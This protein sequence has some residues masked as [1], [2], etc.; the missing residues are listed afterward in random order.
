MCSGRANSRTEAKVEIVYMNELDVGCCHVAKGL[1]LRY[2]QKTRRLGFFFK[3]APLFCLFKCF[4][5]HSQVARFTKLLVLFPMTCW[6]LN[7]CG[8]HNQ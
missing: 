2:A 6:L 1:S 5:V 8:P 4:S 3:K 7:A